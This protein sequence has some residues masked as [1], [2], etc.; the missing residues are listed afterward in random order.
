MKT[1][2]DQ[3]IWQGQAYNARGQVTNYLQGSNLQTQKYYN[4]YGFPTGEMTYAGSN[5]LNYTNYSFDSQKGNLTSRTDY[6]AGKTESFIYDN[7]NRLTNENVYNGVQLTT[8]FALNGNITSKSDIGTYTYGE[9]GPHAVTGLTN[10]TGT[11]LP[12]FDQTVDYTAFNKASYISQGDYS[13]YITYGPD[14]QRSKTVLNQSPGETTI[15]TK[16]YAFGDY[17]KE[18]T[19]DCTRHLHYIAGGDGIAAIYVKYDNAPDSLYF[20]L[21]DH[22]G[23]IVGAINNETGTVFRQNFDAWGRKRNPVTWS[24][25][26]IPEFPFDRGYTGHEN[27]K[28]FGLINMN[29]RM[30]D[31]ALGRFLSPDMIVQNPTNTQSYNR[32]SYCLNNPLKYVDPSGYN[33]I[34]NLMDSYGFEGSG[35]YYRGMYFQY[36]SEMGSFNAGNGKV[37]G[38]GTY[39]YDWIHGA[40]KNPNG[41]AIS[42]D[43]FQQET[44]NIPKKSANNSTNNSSASN[45]TS[46]SNTQDGECVFVF[47]Y[48]DLWASDLVGFGVIPATLAY[49]L[50][51]QSGGNFWD[52]FI[53]VGSKINNV[54]DNVITGTSGFVVGVQKLGNV[55]SK[56]YPVV[57]KLPVLTTLGKLT[58]VISIANNFN[59]FL[60]NPSQNWWNGVEAA[61]Q[62]GFMAFGGAQ[63]NLIYNLSVMTIDL[64]I[65][66]VNYYKRK[67]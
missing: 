47:M 67:K 49:L 7:L 33:Y 27:L 3:L 24:Y 66:G 45:N 22:L 41:Q 57:T 29:G 25:S 58:G 9:A 20:I 56:E 35:F 37:I 55:V 30:Y 48:E 53:N 17:E 54:A 19:D 6:L 4:S 13:Y 59:Q 11:L 28:W 16:Y 32:Y 63:A 60:D 39:H 15:L 12:A 65:E 36:N 50:H 10:T 1:Q 42:W 2:N 52:N 26:N 38:G 5:T 34:D 51:A 64:T 61:G 43:Q 23:S 62:I 14:R 8:G 46:L 31:A 44:L 18:T 40:Y 21:K